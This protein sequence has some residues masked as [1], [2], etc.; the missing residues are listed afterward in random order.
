MNNHSHFDYLI[1]GAGAAGL[2]LAEAIAKDAFFSDKTILLLDKDAKKTNDRTWCFWEKGKGQFDTIIH[3]KWN[4]IYFG[5]KQFSKRFKI[6]PYSYKMV[7]GI[8]FYTS[9]LKRIN[10]SPNIT[11]LQEI[12]KEVFQSVNGATVVTDTS[13]YTAQQVFNSIFDYK[14][15]THQQKYPV[16]QQHFVGWFIKTSVPIFDLNQ[17]T[18]MDF[19]IP[20]KGNTRFMYVLPTSKNEALVEYTLFSKDLLPKAVYENAIKDYLNTNLGCS[21]YEILET[22]I[23]SIPMT[24]YDFTAHNTPNIIHIGTAGGWAKPS[25]GYTFLSTAKKIPKLIEY[26]KKR[27]PLDQLNFKNRFWLYDLLFLDVL[28]EDNAKGYNI[29]ETLFKNR[30]PRL[31]FKF[32]DEETT[33]YED[34]KCIL[35]CPKKP[36]IKALL[37]RLA[38]M[39]KTS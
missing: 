14:M 39:V 36:F 31:I 10:A 1:I 28:Y 37:R 8:D 19:S 17:A 35:G 38:S 18:Y 22:E 21:D 16:L 25:T 3:K 13:R 2:M 32:L 26:I 23:G 24:S 20:Q 33:L 15:V 27:K 9:Y 7:R 11:F 30:N 4:H 12:V 6:A 5:G 29:F 34:F